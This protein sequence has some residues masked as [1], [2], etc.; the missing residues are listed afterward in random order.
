MT[1]QARKNL[2]VGGVL[3]L[4]VAVLTILAYVTPAF[5]VPST[6]KGHTSSI[7]DLKT[8]MSQVELVTGRMAEKVDNTDK[9]TERIENKLDNLI[10]RNK[11]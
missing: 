11:Q 10:F 4:I 3:A 5:L 2:S 9:R 1:A 7:D 8:R 6:L